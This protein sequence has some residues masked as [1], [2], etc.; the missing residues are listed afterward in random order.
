MKHLYFPLGCL[1]LGASFVLGS[2]LGKP[3][4]PVAPVAMITSAAPAAAAVPGRDGGVLSLEE[5]AAYVRS[6]PETLKQ[7][8]RD[9]NFE[10]AK[11]QGQGVQVADTYRYIP[12]YEFKQDGT[13]LFLKEELNNWLQFKMLDRK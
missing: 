9:D 4:A 2:Y 6:T 7:L 11:I 13:L 12:Y 1:I 3:D 8:I 5:A 10:R